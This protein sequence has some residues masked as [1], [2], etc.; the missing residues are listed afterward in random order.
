MVLQVQMMFR[1]LG[2]R[3]LTIV[4]NSNQVEGILTRS[5]LS[6]HIH[7]G[8]KLEAAL[9]ESVDMEHDMELDPESLRVP[10]DDTKLDASSS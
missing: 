10:Q 3:H 5:D 7:D 4:N 1:S 6:D 2:L 9:D 8:H